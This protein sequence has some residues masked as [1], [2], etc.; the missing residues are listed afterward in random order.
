MANPLYFRSSNPGLANVNTKA[1]KLYEWDGTGE[2]PSELALGKGAMPPAEI[3]GETIIWADSF[4]LGYTSEANSYPVFFS[5]GAA[6]DAKILRMIN[7][8]ANRVGQPMFNDVAAAKVWASTVGSVYFVEAGAGASPAG[9]QWNLNTTTNEA[10]QHIYTNGYTMFDTNPGTW[11]P[12]QNYFRFATTALDG[13]Y[14]LTAFQNLSNG[15]IKVA[16]DASNYAI[17]QVTY[18]STNNYSYTNGAGETVNLTIN[19]V[20]ETVGS[21][22]AQGNGS[23][24]PVYATITMGAT[25]A[26]LTPTANKVYDLYAVNNIVNDEW[27]PGMINY[28][29]PAYAGQAWP[30]TISIPVNVIDSNGVNRQAELLAA[31]SIKIYH[32]ASN[33]VTFDVTS[34]YLNV[35]NG[36]YDYPP[37]DSNPSIVNTVVNLSVTNMVAVGVAP[38]LANPTITLLIN[39][40]NLEGSGSTPA[41]T[42]THTVSDGDVT[43]IIEN[44]SSYLVD[45]LEFTN[46]TGGTILPYAPINA[47]TQAWMPLENGESVTVSGVHRWFTP[48]GIYVSSLF[49]SFDQGANRIFKKYVNDILVDTYSDSNTDFSTNFNRPSNQSLQAGDVIKYVIENA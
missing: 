27:L 46:S 19:S 3:S 33:Y 22:P 11:T 20:V 34:T 24:N 35:F 45:L 2:M 4:T 7:H 8:V 26:D 6:G 49:I 14:N 15:Y 44:N 40:E 36:S 23:V 47:S 5:D 38:S 39:G 32:D 43:M 31:T 17:Y 41:S 21:R 9:L 16:I 29:S 1:T 12:G 42:Y 30:S 18:T 10:N 25:V 28:L 48:G 37:Y 13:T